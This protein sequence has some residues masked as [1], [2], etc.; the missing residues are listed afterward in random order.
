MLYKL[1]WWLNF[2]GFYLLVKKNTLRITELTVA[3]CYVFYQQ[4]LKV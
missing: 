1:L 2:T 4:I 3:V